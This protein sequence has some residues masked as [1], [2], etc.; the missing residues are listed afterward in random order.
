VAGGT[1]LARLAVVARSPLDESLHVAVP[2]DLLWGGDRHLL[3]RVPRLIRGMT[4]FT[5]HAWKSIVAGGSVVAGSVATEAVA[6]FRLSLQVQFKEGVDP[7]SGVRRL[8]PRLVL[9]GVAFGAA[10]RA[11]IVIMRS[12]TAFGY[13]NF[14][15]T[16]RR[17]Q[18]GQQQS[19]EHHQKRD[20]QSEPV[21]VCPHGVPLGRHSPLGRS[22]PRAISAVGRE[23]ALRS[24]PR[25]PAGEMG[26][27]IARTLAVILW[28]TPF[29]LPTGYL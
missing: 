6:R 3:G 10:L 21:A 13:G 28:G 22:I 7:C 27:L 8:G 9:H 11:V 4:C 17:A 12:A 19:T 16:G 5:G 23:V 15:Q 1:V 20:A 26:V 18:P 29:I 25:Q 2:A 24:K 14:C